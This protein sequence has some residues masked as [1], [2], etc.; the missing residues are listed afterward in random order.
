MPSCGPAAAATVLRLFLA[1]EARQCT[2]KL[3]IEGVCD[4]TVDVDASRDGVVAHAL[5]GVVAHALVHDE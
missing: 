5:D 1:R 2:M 4:D 3:L